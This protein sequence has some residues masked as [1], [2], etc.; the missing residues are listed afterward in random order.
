MGIDRL[1]LIDC[2]CMP[3]YLATSHKYLR[4][5]VLARLV[6]GL[7]ELKLWLFAFPEVYLHQA[8]KAKKI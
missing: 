2:G 1:F 8:L 4:L 3:H 7:L 6:V 5:W